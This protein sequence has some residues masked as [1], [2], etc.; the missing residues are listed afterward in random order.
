LLLIWLGSTALALSNISSLTFSWTPDSVLE[1]YGYC[2]MKALT[3]SV[4]AVHACSLL[5]DFIIMGLS[6]YRLASMRRAARCGFWLVLLNDGISWS[7]FTLPPTMG[8]VFTFYLGKTT[9]AQGI[10]LVISSTMHAIIACRAYRNLSDFADTLPLSFCARDKVRDGTM[11]DQE[12]LARLAWFTGAAGAEE[13]GPSRKGASKVDPATG[14]RLYHASQPS[15]FSF[16]SFSGGH[17]AE[18]HSNGR[19]YHRQSTQP[20][21]AAP[22]RPPA[23]RSRIV[24]TICTEKRHHSSSSCSSEKDR[25][26]HRRTLGSL[27]MLSAQVEPAA[28]QT[29]H[30]VFGRASS[31]ISPGGREPISVQITTQMQ[32]TG[33]SIDGES[34][35]NHLSP[36][37]STVAPHLGSPP[38]R[39]ARCEGTGAGRRRTQY[40]LRRPSH[41]WAPALA[42]TLD[43][44]PEEEPTQSLAA[45]FI[46]HVRNDVALDPFQTRASTAT[47]TPTSADAS[48]L[49]TA[50]NPFWPV[51]EVEGRPRTARGPPHY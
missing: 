14:D 43:S 38:V 6:A 20:L 7:L 47:T 31:M 44:A 10:A 50:V 17:G 16:S 48:P 3:W 4:G 12:T 26:S 32:S 27:D 35:D 34:R 19:A 33:D 36:S 5:I 9:P 2:T 45:C 13:E 28:V 1:G 8:A 23:Y 41:V 15:D 21:R 40:V 18:E 29:A 51:G 42:P 24:S 22:E 37:P 49:E 25:P 11:L 39:P 46:H 30:G